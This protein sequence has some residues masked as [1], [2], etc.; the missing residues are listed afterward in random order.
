MYFLRKIHVIIK[1]HV[2]KDEAI[3]YHCHIAKVFFRFRQDCSGRYT[4]I[5][6]EIQV[7]P[8]A[9]KLG[10]AKLILWQ[11][12]K[13]CERFKC[14]FVVSDPYTQTKG[15]LDRINTRFKNSLPIHLQQDAFIYDDGRMETGITYELLLRL[16]VEHFNIENKLK[17]IHQMPGYV[18]EL[19]PEMFPSAAIM[20]YGPNQSSHAQAD[21]NAQTDSQT[22]LDFGNSGM[23]KPSV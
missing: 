23:G 5:L 2:C 4:A 10:I 7:R 18:L 15:I 1:K 14:D 12:V 9:T 6:S 22:K 20:N 19:I 8:C 3:V 21:S 13:S 17:F 11:I 16:K